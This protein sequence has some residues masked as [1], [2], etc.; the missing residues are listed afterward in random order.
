MDNEAKKL[1]EAFQNAYNNGCYATEV[2]HIEM[3]HALLEYALAT[4]PKDVA[5][6]VEEI[7]ENTGRWY[8]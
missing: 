4:L 7:W 3:D 6:K 5:A 1:L 2:T 8:A